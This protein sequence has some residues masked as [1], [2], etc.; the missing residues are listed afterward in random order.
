VEA[1]EASEAVERGRPGRPGNPWRSAQP[2]Q[3]SMT[4]DGGL[5]RLWRQEKSRGDL[6]TSGTQGA[7]IAVAVVV[8]D[9]GDGRLWRLEV[10]GFRSARICTT[11]GL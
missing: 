7:C 10:G 9:P 5:W 8:D 4:R 1:A 11:T 6:D 3:P 2:P